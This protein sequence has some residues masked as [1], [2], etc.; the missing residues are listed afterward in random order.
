MPEKT[1]RDSLLGLVV[2]YLMVSVSEPERGS[3]QTE[4]GEKESDG[5][6]RG[7][8]NHSQLGKEMTLLFYQIKPAPRTHR[9]KVVIFSF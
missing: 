8:E 6:E 9:L 5:E 4:T 7:E 1:V 3:S 2:H